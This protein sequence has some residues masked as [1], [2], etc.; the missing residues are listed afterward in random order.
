M[1]QRTRAFAERRAQVWRRPPARAGC[2]TGWCGDQTRSALE[3]RR[4][5]AQPKAPPACGRLESHATTISA[6]VQCA[7]RAHHVARADG[8]LWRHA[9]A[10]GS[11]AAAARAIQL[12]GAEL[13]NRVARVECI[14][15]GV[16]NTHRRKKLAEACLNV[17]FR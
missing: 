16:S 5:S 11:C 14:R 13:E 1:G 7:W 9:R 12:A 3:L 17:A 4:W 10:R 15:A 8:C 2:R 6:L